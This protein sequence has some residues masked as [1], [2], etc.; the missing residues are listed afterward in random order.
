MATEKPD[1]LR[2]SMIVGSMWMVAMRWAIKGTGVVSTLILVRV[3]APE[4]FGLIAM[5]SMVIGLLHVLSS[6]GVDMA[7]IQRADATN[8]HF[9]TAWTI[10]FIQLAAVAA[11]LFAF[12]PLTAAT[13]Q[14]R[15]TMGRPQAPSGP[16][17]AREQ[18]CA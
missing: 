15:G 11:C 2:R 7:L 12:A 13:S 10:R 14:Q 6:F 8:E 9:D 1:S 3:L 16:L 5:G 4:D 17:R 18:S